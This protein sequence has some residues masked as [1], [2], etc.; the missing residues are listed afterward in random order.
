[1][2]YVFEKNPQDGKF[3]KLGKF[4]NL[5]NLPGNPIQEIPGRKKFEVLWEKGNGNFPLNIPVAKQVAESIKVN[6]VSAKEFI[7]IV[8]GDPANVAWCML[9][10]PAVNQV[11][12]QAHVQAQY[13]QLCN[14]FQDMFH[15]KPGLPPCKQLDH[16]IDLI[17]ES[18]SPPKCQQYWLI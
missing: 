12:G 2:G 11:K 13:V 17:N 18:L 14:K 4:P 7:N 8:H 9:V 15:S 1:M 10:C 16:A 6:I 5:R 3:P